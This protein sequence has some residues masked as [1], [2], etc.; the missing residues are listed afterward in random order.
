[1]SNDSGDSDE[2]EALFDS[3]LEAHAEKL[4]PAPAPVASPA[5]VIAAEPAVIAATPEASE[6]GGIHSHIGHL[7]RA[8]HDTMR[9][10]GYDKTLERAVGKMPDTR[11]R[12]NYIS[13]LTEQA[14]VKTLNA[15]EETKPM[16]QKLE[17]GATELSA[18]WQALFERKLD[19]E[20]FK[21][22]VHQT[23]NY[24]QDVPLNTKATNAKLMDVVVAQDY[25]DLT[26]QVLKKLAETVQQLENQLVALLIE[27]LPEDKKKEM[28]ASLLN[29]PVINAEGRS[30]VVTNQA[31]VDDLLESL[32]F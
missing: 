15:V 5:P 21:A 1:M 9:E 4:A 7:T 25:Q 24:L 13:T 23:R 6:S 31:Q 19:T 14:A 10:L 12:L 26:G 27:T 28:D 20:Q 29:G 2:L 18:Q 30:D 22:L 3:I 11:D 17:S 8:L 16:Q 32:G